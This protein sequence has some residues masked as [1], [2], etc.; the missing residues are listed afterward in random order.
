[1][2]AKNYASKLIFSIVFF[3]FIF[4]G[5]GLYIHFF[6]NEQLQ[7]QPHIIHAN[8]I[9]SGITTTISKD[10]I[11]SDLKMDNNGSSEKKLL[12]ELMERSKKV[13]SN[14]ESTN[15]QKKMVK[16]S[17]VEATINQIVKKMTLREKIGQLM[18]VGFPSKV[19]DAHIKEMIQDYKV[20]GVI[21]YDRNMESPY[22]VGRL[23]KDL[24][25]LSAK[26]R[27][28]IPMLVS[29]DQEGGKV[30]RMKAHVSTI[31]SQQEL[32]KLNRDKEVLN[33]A[34]RTGKELLKMGINVNFA[35]VLDLSETDSRSF[36]LDAKKTGILGEQVVKGLTNVGV[37]ATLKHFPGNGRSNIDPHKET[38]SVHAGKADLEG[39]DIYPFKKII[40]ELDDN[41]FFVMV[42]HIKYPAYDAVNPASTSS[43][44]INDLLRKRL[45][46]QG[47]VVTDDLE[48]GA[49]SKYDSY[50]D[51][52]VKSIK[53][54][55]DLL[56]VCHT[57]EAQK[58]VY[59]GIQAAV[60]SNQLSIHKIDEAVK[61]VLRYKLMNLN[62]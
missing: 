39:K 8:T 55:A 58:E 40:D 14:V 22:Q 33:I 30:V 56:L 26:N 7:P 15:P 52:G 41:K 49:V 54:G 28:Q 61:R 36:G 19:V 6:T 2:R 25:V 44:I 9:V 32:G 29:V 48:M 13:E 46:F 10:E 35:P 37:A 18:V 47:V 23:T 57:L 21:Y 5:G 62:S 38:S 27:F 11:Q 50:R 51:L 43:I 53:A 4:V 20:G 24:Q 17:N 3:L 1:M 12:N 60:N 42:T 34:S 31:P 16:N 45:G 59:N